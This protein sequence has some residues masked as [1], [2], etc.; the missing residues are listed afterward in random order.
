LRRYET[1]SATSHAII[2][3]LVPIWRNFHELLRAHY[4]DYV[5]NAAALA[6]MWAR[7]VRFW[8]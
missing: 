8:A 6:C 2:I 4:G 7:A 1:S 3:Y 5:I